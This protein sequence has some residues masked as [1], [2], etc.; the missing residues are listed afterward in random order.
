MSYYLDPHADFGGKLANEIPN[1]KQHC[2]IITGMGIAMPYGTLDLFGHS[3]SFSK[4]R[5]LDSDAF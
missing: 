3:A 5:S 1:Q 4:Y 2:S